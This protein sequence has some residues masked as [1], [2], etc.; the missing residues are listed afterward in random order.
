M[1]ITK[2][3]WLVGVLNN[4]LIQKKNGNGVCHSFFCEFILDKL[5]IS[6]SFFVIFYIIHIYNKMYNILL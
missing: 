1:M 4:I 5:G 2:Y 6:K 3:I